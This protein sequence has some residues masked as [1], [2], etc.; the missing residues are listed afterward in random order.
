[1]VD[2][3]VLDAGGPFF[4]EQTVGAGGAEVFAHGFTKALIAVPFVDRGGGAPFE[5]SHCLFAL[6][7]DAL[8]DGAVELFVFDLKRGLET[9]EF[10]GFLRGEAADIFL[11]DEL[12]ETQVG[13][14]GFVAEGVEYLGGDGVLAFAR[15]SGD[16]L[17]GFSQ[18]RACFLAC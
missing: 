4:F 3:E 2:L 1:M 15:K 17:D 6:A 10:G 18:Q 8:Q 7:G 11:L 5:M 9:V 16:A 14:T 13:G 12:V